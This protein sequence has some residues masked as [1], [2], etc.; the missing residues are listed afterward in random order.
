MFSMTTWESWYQNVSI[1][2]Y[3]GT[4]DNGG[5]DDNWRCAK[6]QSNRFSE[7]LWGSLP[8]LE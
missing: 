2:D 7:D 5:G 1:L 4:K 8:K 3:I 6:L